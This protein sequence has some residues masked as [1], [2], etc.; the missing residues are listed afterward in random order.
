MS[1]KENFIG[2]KHTKGRK[3]G[4]P[5]LWKTFVVLRAR[6]PPTT[7]GRSLFKG[8]G[9]IGRNGNE[10]KWWLILKVFCPSRQSNLKSILKEIN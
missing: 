4:L 9:S 6:A 8:T 2:V 5:S 3:E 7:P 1:E 10:M